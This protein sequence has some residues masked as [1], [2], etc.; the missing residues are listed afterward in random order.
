MIYKNKGSKYDP[1]NYRPISLLP[2]FGKIFEKLISDK[3]YLWCDLNNILNKEQS[4]F[5]KGR[6]T[7]DHLFLLTQYV[8]EGFNQKKQT[9][10]IF[11]DFEK[12]F[13]KIWQEGLLF[14]LNSLNL[15]RK[16]VLLIKSFLEERLCF[17][18]LNGINSFYFS[19][20]SGLPQGSCLSPILFIIFVSDIPTFKEVKISQYADDI[21]LYLHVK[22]GSCTLGKNIK[23]QHALDTLYKWCCKWNLK[24]NNNKTNL[25]S[26]HKI[27]KVNNIYHINNEPL[28]TVNT[29]KFLGIK[30]D[31]KLNFNQHIQETINKNNFW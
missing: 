11:I 5:R 6:S 21:A 7:N 19:P 22:R 8:T 23:L 17:I 3:L 13:D 1:T 20:D 2:Q 26:F 31:E 16:D 15:P 28:Q 9:D 25:L 14:K 27:H 4:G 12:C 18:S 30:F 10:A 29:I 24:I